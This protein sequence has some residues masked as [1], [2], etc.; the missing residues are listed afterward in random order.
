MDADWLPSNLTNDAGRLQL[1][2]LPYAGGGTAL[3]HRIRRS[4]PSTVEL[5][6]LKLAGRESRLREPA[7][8]D[9]AELVPQVAGVIARRPATQVA[10]LGYSLG[11]LLGFEVCRVLR[12]EYGLIPKQLIVASCRA[13]HLL[14]NE[15][16]HLLEDEEFVDQ[17]SS[18]YGGITPE[19]LE[20]PRVL[21]LLLPTLRADIKMVETYRHIEQPPLD[22]PIL[23][24]RG[25]DDEQVTV[26]QT[27][28]WQQHT[29]I[30]LNH[31][32]FPGGHFFLNDGSSAAIQWIARRLA[33]NPAEKP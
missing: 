5:V 20:D 28:A 16:L 24:L 30:E 33:T 32:S 25:T 4:L 26:A 14:T 21:K 19:A 13:P 31:R 2:C 23:A 18:R 29:S 15:G 8:E 3:F 10:L 27:A 12:D 7:V 11:G 9:L 1:Y 6:P 17:I 22:I